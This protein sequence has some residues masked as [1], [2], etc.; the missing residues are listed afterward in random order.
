MAG[1]SGIAV[2]FWAGLTISIGGLAGFLG[3]AGFAT[4]IG[5]AACDAVGVGAGFA[6]A[7]GLDLAAGFSVVVAMAG[8]C[9]AFNSSNAFRMDS[10]ALSS[11]LGLMRF[12]G[13]AATTGALCSGGVMAGAGVG[14]GVLGFGV[15][16]AIVIGVWAG[17]FIGFGFSG[18]AG[19]AL[20]GAAVGC[21]SNWDIAWRNWSRARACVS[22]SDFWAWSGRVLA[23]RA[24]IQAIANNFGMCISLILTQNFA[25]GNTF[26]SRPCL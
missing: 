20:L 3:G 22:E 8:F 7:T 9:C 10:R 16:G 21:A 5:G 25:L 12:D 4:A 13:V 14:A 26:D 19:M 6:T 18:A 15:A 2:A 24:A 23:P 17:A 1:F 11:S